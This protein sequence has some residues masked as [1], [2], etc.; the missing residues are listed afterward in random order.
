MTRRR[1]LVGAGV[2]VC[3]L[4][5]ALC[6]RPRPPAALPGTERLDDRTFWTLASDLSEPEGYFRSD[7]LVSNETTFQAVIPE[8]ERRTTP[9]GIYVGV[10]PEQNFTYIVALRPRLAFIVDIRRQNLLLH[11]LYKALMELSPDRADFVSRLFSRPR[12]PALD[13]ASTASAIFDAYERVEPSRPLFLETLRQVR[14]R[15]VRVHGFALSAEDLHVIEVVF[16]A[17]YTG[18]PDITY[19]FRRRARGYGGFR[20]FFGWPGRFPSYAT[21]MTGNDGRNRSYLSTEAGFQA[22][23]ALQEANR[24]VPVVGDFAGD[25]ALRAL[26]DYLRRR[27]ER[28]TAFYTSNVEQY[29]FRGDD[30]RR[31]FANVSALP[32]DQSSTFIRA[33][34]NYRFRDPGT[35]PGPR[36][37]TL[38]NP[39]AR[40]LNAYHQGRIQGYDDVIA[41]SM[42]TSLPTEP[43]R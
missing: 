37:V 30:W 7:N 39:I 29:L 23:K 6:V 19:A 12:P 8:L 11:L 40:L 31:F 15:L 38:L 14:D 27:G 25:R 13:A 43:V 10:G 17:F 35:P 1:T 36:S 22:L 33:Y 28:V 5:G 34:F 21:L 42:Q 4:L 16:D 41:L 9:G 26:G 24:I 20:G 32:V 3:L 18:G 2:A